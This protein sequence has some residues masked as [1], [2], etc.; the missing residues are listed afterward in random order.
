MECLFHQTNPRLLLHRLHEMRRRSN[1]ARSENERE[2]RGEGE[3]DQCDNATREE[4][5]GVKRGEKEYRNTND[6]VPA[7]NDQRH[8]VA[9]RWVVRHRVVGPCHM[10]RHE[11]QA[12][13]RHQNVDGHAIAMRS[14]KVRVL[15]G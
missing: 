9:L 10:H 3:H 6:D 11:E 1:L 4:S 15:T 5:L 14:V 12:L 2:E 7:G 8:A 13:Q